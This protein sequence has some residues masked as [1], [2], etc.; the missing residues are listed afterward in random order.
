M[1]D[2]LIVGL[3]PAW[4]KNLY[5]PKLEK[6]GVNR[7]TRM[8]TF[9][10]GKGLNVARTLNTLGHKV[11]LL[12]I[13]GGGAGQRVKNECIECGIEPLCIQVKEE[14]RSCT[15]LIEENEGIVSEVIEPFCVNDS[16]IHER[17]LEKVQNSSANYDMVLL[18]GTAPEGCSPLIFEKIYKAMG[19]PPTLL[20]SYKGISLGLLKSVDIIKV[21][22]EELKVFQHIYKDFWAQMSQNTKASIFITGSSMASYYK[23][24]GTGPDGWCT[25]HYAIPR[26]KVVNTI[27]AG[28]T[29]T[30][31]LAHGIAAGLPWHRAYKEAL[32]MASASCRTHLPGVFSREH[33]QEILASVKVSKK[34]GLVV[35]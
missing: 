31:G 28:D 23:Y 9:A 10:A 16:Q 30:A 2:F 33:Y 24:E 13:T 4:Q 1:S 20:D 8:E 25:W 15:T 7:A 35:L 32:A 27:G 22:D 14:T 26:I 21:N 17:V 18:C 12:Q 34:D 6:G 5:F 3:N 11:S 19:G 29:V